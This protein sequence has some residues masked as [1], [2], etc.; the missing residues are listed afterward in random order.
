LK[1]LRNAKSVLALHF[2]PGGYH[3]S[4]RKVGGIATPVA[5]TA[6][7]ACAESW[8]R[9]RKRLPWKLA[10]T[11]CK[12]SSPRMTSFHSHSRSVCFYWALHSLGAKIVLISLMAM[13][14]EPASD[15]SAKNWSRIA[16]FVVKPRHSHLGQSACLGGLDFTLRHS[17]LSVD[18]KPGRP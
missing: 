8:L 9:N 3:W 15:C 1:D 11:C 4:S 12:A 7:E 17:A 13:F 6:C 18:E 16:Q 14:P 10:S 5:R 2:P